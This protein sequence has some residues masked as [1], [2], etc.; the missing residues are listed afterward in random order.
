MVLYPCRQEKEVDRWPYIP[1]VGRK[2]GTGTWW[3]EIPGGGGKR[4]TMAR[5]PRRWEKEVDRWPD[6]R[7]CV[8]EVD[9]W[10][11]IPGGG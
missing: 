6:P 4:G 8:R 7:R 2:R 9:R 1:G 3:P 10:P 5:G 11:E